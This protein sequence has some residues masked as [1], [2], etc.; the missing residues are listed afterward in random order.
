M[1]SAIVALFKHRFY[2]SD[3]NPYSTPSAR[4]AWGCGYR[5]AGYVV[6]Y[7]SANDNY[8]SAYAAGQRAK[9]LA[10][11]DLLDSAVA[12]AYAKVMD[13]RGQSIPDSEWTI[14]LRAR[15]TRA[16]ST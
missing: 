2:G 5:G 11:L 1:D 15:A 10:D 13:G 8:P 14:V 6:G 3:L 12:I 16:S 9:E 7:P 4:S